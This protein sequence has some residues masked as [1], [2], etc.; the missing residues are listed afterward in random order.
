MARAVSACG[1]EWV[2]TAVARR[3]A[4][5]PRLAVPGI[6]I[7]FHTNA[8]EKREMKM[9]ADESILHSMNFDS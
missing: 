2:K 5:D 1:Y 3:V 4:G 7:G 6:Q 8:V 9:T